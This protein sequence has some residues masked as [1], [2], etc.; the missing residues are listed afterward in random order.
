MK[1]A[2]KKTRI[3]IEK[4]A[5]FSEQQITKE[6]IKIKNQNG[7]LTNGINEEWTLRKTEK[8]DIWKDRP[9]SARQRDGHHD[10]DI[11]INIS[12]DMCMKIKRRKVEAETEKNEC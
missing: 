8:S 5:N 11:T 2:I 4:M 6:R 1:K 7:K 10:R 9:T 12:L 3:S